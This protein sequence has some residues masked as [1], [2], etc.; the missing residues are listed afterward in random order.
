[1][2]RRPSENPQNRFA[3][4]AVDYDEGE[5][6][7]PA[8]V[9]LLEDASRSILSHNESPDVG[10]DWSVNPYRGCLTACAYCYARPTH[11]VLDLGAGTD[12]DT[13]ILVKRRAPELL[14]EAFEAKSWKGE[15]VAFA[16]S[17]IRPGPDALRILVE[18]LLSSPEAGSAFAPGSPAGSPARTAPARQQT[19]V[20]TAMPIPSLVISR[21]LPATR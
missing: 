2:Q 8:T 11:E 16:D 5:G 6:P 9:T 17:D 15:L 7:P 19:A 12:F 14:R 3:K 20:T 1:M 13:K 4:L 18:T 21:P 10:F